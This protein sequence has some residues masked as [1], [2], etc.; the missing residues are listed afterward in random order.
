MTAKDRFVSFLR[1]RYIDQPPI[2]PWRVAALCLWMLSMA[3][4]TR[5]FSGYLF[6]NSGWLVTVALV[7]L[8]AAMKLSFEICVKISDTI[9]VYCT[10]KFGDFFKKIDNI[11]SSTSKNHDKE[12]FRQVLNRLDKPK[13][14]LILIV[15]FLLTATQRALAQ[16]FNSNLVILMMM[17]LF[18]VV[19]KAAEFVYFWY[20]GRK[21][22]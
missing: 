12:D 9:Q 22:P 16:N 2:N 14:V 21:S 17:G 15:S 19:M 1:K 6:F 5:L 4:F 11:W 3:A 18:V 20:I 8:G 7:L 10:R 13:I